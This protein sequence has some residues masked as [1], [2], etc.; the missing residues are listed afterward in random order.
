MKYQAI[1]VVLTAYACTTKSDF[2]TSFGII[3]VLST[4]LFILLIVSF[5]VNSPFLT[6]LYCCIGVL[7]FGVY[8]VIDTQLIVGG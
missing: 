1:V 5:F 8:L 7:L 6:N 2:T 4:C 3:L